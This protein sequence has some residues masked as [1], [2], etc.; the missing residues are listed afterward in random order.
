MKKIL[1]L[2]FF[3]LAY[4]KD[5]DSRFCTTCTSS[6]T[7]NFEVCREGNGDASVNGEDTNTN[8][9]VYLAGLEKAGATCG[10]R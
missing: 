10:G 7:L 5:D 2:L 3:T 9:E 4:C 8:Y 1:F 6:E